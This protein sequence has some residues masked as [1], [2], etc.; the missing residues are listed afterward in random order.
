MA[1][2]ERAEMLTPLGVSYS[3]NEASTSLILSSSSAACG[4]TMR[5]SSAVPTAV[6]IAQL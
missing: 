1:P 6:A 4:A 3:T 5:M 2:I